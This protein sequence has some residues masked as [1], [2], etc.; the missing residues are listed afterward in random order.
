M[1]LAS[2]L[3]T[4]LTGL[5]TAETKIDVVGNNLANSQTVGFKE[6][7]VVV[8]SQFLQTLTLGSAPSSTSGGTN[9]RQIGMGARVNEIS[10]TFSQGTVQTS[11]NPTD[12]ALQGDGFFIVEGGSGE[13]LYTRSGVFRTNEA[14]EL[15][16]T[17][18]NRLLGFSV[19][20]DFQLVESQL[21]PID[22][23]VGSVRV[24]QATSNVALEGVLPPSGDVADAGS[25]SDSGILG[26]GSVPRPGTTAVMA[27]P[28]A[29]P[30][31]GG[32]VATTPDGGGTHIEG[33]LYRYKFA[34]L[35]SAGTES[36]VSSEL[37]VTVAGADGLPNNQIQLN[38]LPTL[39][40]G[41]YTQLRIYRTQPNGSNF[42]RLG[43]VDLTA[44][45]SFTDTDPNGIN[46]AQPLDETTLSGNYSY[47]V[48]WSD[49]NIESR[50]TAIS[51]IVNVVDGRVHLQG[52]P[53]P[54]IPGPSDTF[55]AFDRIKI[56]RNTAL[57]SSSYYSVGEIN[58]SV[59]TEFTDTL[60]DAQIVANGP[61]PL[62]GP[63]I[64]PVTLLTDV[65]TRDQLIYDE[66]FQLGTLSF[67]ARK[68]GRILQTGMFEITATSTVQELM[69]FISDTVGIQRVNA[70]PTNP[71]PGSM[72]NIVGE[73]GT[74]VP[75]VSLTLDGRIRVISNNG[76]NN[77][78]ELGSAISAV[79]PD[80]SVLP[81]L[82]S[83]N[84]SQ[85]AVGQSAV[86]DFV[87]Y[88]SLGIPLD[89]RVTT[90]LEARSG[91]ESTY[92]W[93]AD[94]S[95]N[96]P[97]SG[98][99]ITVGTGLIRFDGEGNYL[100]ASNSQISIDRVS[101]PS[102]SPLNFDLDFSTVSGLEAESASLAAAR[103]DG[104]SPG[105]LTNFSIGEDGVV[106]GAFSNG[107]SRTL[108][109]VRL[110]RFANPAGLEQQGQN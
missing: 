81:T 17:N 74:L 33:D 87:V 7:E 61:A 37:S 58:P 23:P 26:D 50:P 10:P 80:G 6:S 34:Y 27:G 44:T 41:E 72:N 89:V 90:V 78:I 30:V 52:L 21:S 92:R 106:R 45:T 29:V 60:T 105:T 91:V 67:A 101:I 51:T 68:G 14:N 79:A 85:E 46:L 107:V 28:A 22:I 103:Q 73:V 19:D 55:P 56:Y 8:T 24:A 5:T 62:E 96:D 20:E 31:P 11:S 109:Q 3:S 63:A 108:G 4:A 36:T 40:S 110:A 25:V 66:T 32:I 43:T 49:G 77:G 48:S 64:T 104:S 86:T 38:N 98:G 84:N 12:L 18:G 99:A 65:L 95:D 2:A 53:T 82:I 9:P 39:A 100:S 93:F 42:F 75:G 97:V 102:S 76:V 1:G 59:T 70:D 88:D 54:P 16:T 47:L 57:D 69:D 94:S 71:I 83:F 15:V 13:P 35:D